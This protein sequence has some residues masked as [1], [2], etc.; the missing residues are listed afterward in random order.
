MVTHTVAQPVSITETPTQQFVRGLRE[1]ADWYE[2]H[3]ATPAPYRSDVTIY[4]ATRE[5]I[6]QAARD[7]G[8]CEKEYDDDSFV[9]SRQFGQL[10]LR[11]YTSRENVCERV[12]RTE[13]IPES[14][15]EIV[16]WRCEPILAADSEAGAA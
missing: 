9:L 2:A 8:K 1:L 3:P 10:R 15:K 7:L 16:E 5:Q 12:V 11:F 13:V 6:A 14:V 4:G